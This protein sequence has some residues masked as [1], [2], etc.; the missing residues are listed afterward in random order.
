MAFCVRWI[1]SIFLSLYY[2]YEPLNKLTQYFVLSS[3]KF[4][5][6]HIGGHILIGMRANELTFSKKR[7]RMAHKILGWKRGKG[8]RSGKEVNW[9]QF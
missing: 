2:I 4:P 5:K 9:N 6:P 8:K 3:E 7:N 1:P